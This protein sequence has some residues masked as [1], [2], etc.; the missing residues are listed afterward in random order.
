MNR[1]AIVV[2][3]ASLLTA[4]V[5]HAA[6]CTVE[7]PGLRSVN[8]IGSV[9]DLGSPVPSAD[10]Y[11]LTVDVDEAAGTFVV[12]RETI[13]VFD[14]NSPGGPV[15]LTMAGAPVAGRIDATGHVRL[16][17]WD[18]N[19]S[20]SGILL[21]Q[22]PS[23]TTGLKSNRQFEEEFPSIGTPLDFATGVLTL[24][25]NSKIASAPIISEPVATNFKITCRLS[26]IPNPA[27]LPAGASLAK[28]R[29]TAKV[30]GAA[31]GDSLVLTAKL[32]PP[33]EGLD[34]AGRDVVVQIGAAPESA[35][36]IAVAH[37]D[38]LGTKGKK[39]LVKDTD[40]SDLRVVA[41][42]KGTDDAPVPTSGS[43]T[44]TPGKKGIAVKLAL[45]GLD[46]A[47]LTGTQQVTVAVGDVSAS[48]SVTVAGSGK[49][50]KL[51]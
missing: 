22:T 48:A 27:A 29:G 40:G 25:G 26:P 5:A 44:L 9:G 7:A 30:T 4:G 31:E 41:G 43:L 23:F 39:H 45:K 20:F 17:P 10:G 6:T 12:R 13:P 24:D 51:K 38:V 50:R 15:E 49:K 11:G 16:D 35:L 14:F 46:L 21:P 42:G 34:V 33:A 47:T 28:P 18:I 3:L 36:L 19:A 1:H 8:H 32:V 37:A 2:V